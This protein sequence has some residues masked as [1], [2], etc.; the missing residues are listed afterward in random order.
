MG[1][2]EKL[3]EK[4]RKDYGKI[5]ETFRTYVSS[6]NGYWKVRDVPTAL[7]FQGWYD[8]AGK[9]SWDQNLK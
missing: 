1:S 3:S 2:D 8:P 7:R 6:N 5:L 9:N 4:D